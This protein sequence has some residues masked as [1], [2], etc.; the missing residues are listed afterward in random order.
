[1]PPGS[2]TG[3]GRSRDG[4]PITGTAVGRDFAGP[5]PPIHP[6]IH[7][8]GWYPYYGWGYPYYGYGYG[9]GYWGNYW[10]DPWYS[11][12]VYIGYAG[13]GAGGYDRGPDE[14]RRM[15][16]I[17]LKA[18]PKDAR[19]YIDGALVGTVDDFDGLS[20]H[21]KL[22]AGT[23]QLEIRA[24]GYEPYTGDLRVEAGKTITERVSLKKI[25]N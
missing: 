11:S 3:Q 24:D 5:R 12:S 15:G 2:Y 25:R 16:S 9:Y 18:S 10:Y 14:G 23:Y 19:V 7:G 17:R 6:P 20:D 1:M 8:G 13:G 22:D 4:R 21:L